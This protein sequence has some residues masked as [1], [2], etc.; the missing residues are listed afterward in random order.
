M[1]L[2]DRVLEAHGGV[3]A[4][5]AAS[6]LEL[7]YRAGGLAFASKGRGLGLHDWHARVDLNR[8]HTEFVDYPEAGRRGILD[9]EHVRIDTSSGEL[10]EE[11]DDPRGAIRSRRALLRWDDLDLLYFGGYAIWGYATF[12]F[13]L[14]LPGVEVE[15][16]GAR[17]LRVRYPD[18]WPV[19][20]REQQFHFD[21]NGLLVRNDYTAEPFGR[22]ARS[23]H[24]CEQH[25][26][27]DGLLMPTRRHVHPRGAPFVTLVRIE[28]D[29]VTKL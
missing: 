3:D 9:G 25:R 1:S 23:T 12:P 5:R 18:G 14:T 8:P 19:H 15:E 2:L 29:E 21:E 24:L 28:I 11:R 26:E 17:R 13:H 6:G 22:W 27:F 16:A 10:V 7:R 4:W 20:S